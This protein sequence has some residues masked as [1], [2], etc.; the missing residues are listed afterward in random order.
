VADAG[1]GAQVGSERRL[2]VGSRPH[3]VE[4]PAER[5]MLTQKRAA[6]SPPSYSRGIGGI[7]IK[8][9]TVPRVAYKQDPH[10]PAFDA[11]GDG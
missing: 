7:E 8:T 9:A 2:T 1:R 3:E 10:A 4:P 6:M 11:R 5:K